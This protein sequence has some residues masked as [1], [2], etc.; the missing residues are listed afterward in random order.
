V[1]CREQ[2]NHYLNVSTN[3]TIEKNTF[4]LTTFLIWQGLSDIGHPMAKTSMWF[5]LSRLRTDHL[6]S[7]LLDDYLL[8]FDGQIDPEDRSG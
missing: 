1:S 2:I 3:N 7:L 6:L 4:L 8:L 5:M